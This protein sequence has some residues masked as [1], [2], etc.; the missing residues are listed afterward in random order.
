MINPAFLSTTYVQIFM[1]TSRIVIIRG[2]CIYILS[3]P[4][5]RILSLVFFIIPSLTAFLKRTLHARSKAALQIYFAVIE[6]LYHLFPFYSTIKKNPARGACVPVVKH[7]S[8]SAERQKIS[9]RNTRGMFHL[10]I[11]SVM[12]IPTLMS[13]SSNSFP[14]AEI[15]CASAHSASLYFPLTA[16]IS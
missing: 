15:L 3:C 5:K 6:L 1:A 4:F 11:F 14:N 9:P 8:L 7:S 12:R 10:Y 16:S 2:H 13:K